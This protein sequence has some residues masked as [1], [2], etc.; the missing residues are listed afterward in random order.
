MNAK[1]FLKKNSST[2][3][4]CVGAAGVI[5]TAV[6]AVKATPKALN[7]I[8]DRK[9]ELDVKE[10]PVKEIVKTTWKCYIPTTLIGLS[11]MA[12]MFGSNVLNKK[13]Q[14]ALISAYSLL[15]SSFKEYK[16]HVDDIYGEDSET[17]IREVIAKDKY[18]E[19]P[20]K[21]ND[22][23][24]LFYDLYACRYFEA[25]LADVYKAQCMLNHVFINY[26]YVSL[27][28]FYDLIGIDQVEYGYEAGWSKIAGETYGYDSIQM[29]IDSVMLDDNLKC[30]VIIMPY[31]PT[32]D[33]LC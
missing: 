3:L 26:D 31:P 16:K 20:F 27:N 19:T 13:T 18:S 9:K 17:K 22:E 7:L 24:Q 8:E 2:I 15:D 10:L 23:K 21:P 14:A 12:C 11:T 28:E 6:S 33:Y 25:T 1:L 32:T 30:Y 4:T 5:A 29:D